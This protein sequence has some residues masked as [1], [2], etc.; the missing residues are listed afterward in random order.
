M[1]KKNFNSDYLIISFSKDFYKFHYAL[2]LASS[3]RAI[4]KNVSVF[5]SGYSC[6]F[7]KKNWKCYDEKKIYKKLE[8]KNMSSIEELFLYCKELE[9]KTFYC[10]TALEFLNI[11]SKDITNLI[12]I[13][14]ISMYSILNSNKQGEIIFI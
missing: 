12:D 4:N 13:K 8:L 2:T 3:L 1:I 6:N 10:E 5:I 9:V 14:P 7:I 11:S